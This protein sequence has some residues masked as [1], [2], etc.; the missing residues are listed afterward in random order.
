MAIT[1][2]ERHELYLGL[3]EVIGRKRATTLM[4]HLPPVGWADVATKR[5]LDHLGTQIRG[6]LSTSTANLKAEL[7]TSTANLKG[8]LSTS[9][10]NLKADLYGRINTWSLAIITANAALTA[11]VVSAFR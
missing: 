5:D 3:E 10:A 1:E 4:E 2:D 11:V 6:E 9:T 8:E 7:S